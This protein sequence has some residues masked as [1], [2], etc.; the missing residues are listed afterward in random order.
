MKEYQNLIGKLLIAVAII[1]ASLVVAN[2]LENLGQLINS[3][4]MS[5]GNLIR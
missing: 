1:V 4:A 2:A 5:L 3:A